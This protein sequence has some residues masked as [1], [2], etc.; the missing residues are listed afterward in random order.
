MPNALFDRV[1]PKLSLSAWAVLCV[2]VRRTRG[3]GKKY[4]A[5]SYEQI[6][7]ATGIKST[8][9]IAKALNEL[10]SEIP[11]GKAILRRQKS[12]ERT[13]SCREAT[14]YAL[15]PHFFMESSRQ[16]PEA[17]TGKEERESGGEFVDEGC[18]LDFEGG[19]VGGP[20]KSEEPE[21][22][23]ASEY[24]VTKET[25]VSEEVGN[26]ESGRA[27]ASPS[28]S[29][30]SRLP[31]NPALLAAVCA[32]TRRDVAIVSTRMRGQLMACA[33]TLER[34]GY[35]GE[36]VELAAERW[37]YPTAPTPAQ[38]LDNIQALLCTRPALP[39]SHAKPSQSAA[40]GNSRSGHDPKGRR[41]APAPARFE[42]AAARKSRKWADWL[43]DLG[44]T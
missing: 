37:P 21:A 6:K 22:L 15:N 16:R 18:A 7:A 14:R 29:L 19:Y 8:A 25:P 24:E 40:T 17:N 10:L 11:F 41:V 44:D 30:S 9:T 28:P 36:D 38:L 3:W 27:R 23:R 35:R 31:K 2:I 26:L 20:S 43:A 33:L 34:A 5:I 12:S 1:Q 32:A 13:A 39:P 42:C 4:D